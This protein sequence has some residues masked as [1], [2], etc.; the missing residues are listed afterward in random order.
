MLAA[1]DGAKV[2][3]ATGVDD[4]DTSIDDNVSDTSNVVELGTVVVAS[5]VVRVVVEVV[6][7][8]TVVVMMVVVVGGQI[9]GSAAHCVVQK[10][11]SVQP[12][13]VNTV[14]PRASQYSTDAQHT[15]LHNNKFQRQQRYSMARNRNETVSKQLSPIDAA[16]DQSTNATFVTVLRHWR[17]CW[18]GRRCGWWRGR[19]RWR[20]FRLN[21]KH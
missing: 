2:D 11:L 5:V 8:A 13:R 4:V 10:P 16:F 6:V 7:G 20:W 3:V 17:R 1:V 9:I 12:C 15:H 19:R 14:S 21:I 18:C